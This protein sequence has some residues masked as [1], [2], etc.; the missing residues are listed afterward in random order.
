[1]L[2][3]SRQNKISPCLPSLQKWFWSPPGKIHYCPPKK[4]SRRP[5]ESNILESRRIYSSNPSHHPRPLRKARRSVVVEGQGQLARS[6][7]P[8]SP[9]GSIECNTPF[10]RCVLRVIGARWCVTKTLYAIADLFF[11]C[12]R[13]FRSGWWAT[14]WSIFNHVCLAV[15]PRPAPRHLGENHISLHRCIWRGQAHACGTRHYTRVST[16]YWKY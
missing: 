12:V 16:R 4:S 2:I 5:C 3:L 9:K 14:L 8:T 11:A 15:N 10:A 1:M 6:S 7:T 13:M